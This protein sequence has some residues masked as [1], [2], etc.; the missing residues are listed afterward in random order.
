VNGQYRFLPAEVLE[1]A[2]L[3]GVKI[4]PML[5]D[6]LETHAVSAPSLAQAL[7]AGGVYRHLPASD[8]TDCLQALVQELPLPAGI[9]RNILLPLFLAREASATTAIGDGIALPHV[10]NPIVVPESRP[11]VSICFL[12]R[13]VDFG[14][15]ASEPVQILFT[16]ICPTV[17]THLQL[18]ARLSYAL[19][20]PQFKGVVMRRGAHEEILAEARRIDESLGWCDGVALS[21]SAL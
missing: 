16:L 4:S 5:L 15:P 14:T 9:D 7:D 11:L 1:W 12:G 2:T 10:R 8:K 19:H 20:D 13:P 3:E 6:H 18:L 21:P 17:R